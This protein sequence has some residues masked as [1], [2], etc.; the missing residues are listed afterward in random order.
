[1]SDNYIMLLDNSGPNQYGYNPQMPPGQMMGHPMSLAAQTHANANA[2]TNNGR[3]ASLHHQSSANNVPFGSNDNT[4]SNTPVSA[5]SAPIAAAGPGS[6]NSVASQGAAPQSHSQSTPNQ[7]QAPTASSQGPQGQ[8]QA[9]SLANLATSPNANGFILKI[10]NL[11]KNITTRE[12]T[13]IFSLVIDDILKIDLNNFD[14]ESSPVIFAYFKTFNTC[15]TTLKL[16]N[17]KCIFGNDVPIHVEIDESL[18]FDFNNLSINSAAAAASQPHSSTAAA[19]SLPNSAGSLGPNR[20]RFSFND[21]FQEFDP[22]HP[23]AN[24]PPPAGP[25]QPPLGGSSS[26]QQPAPSSG[27][28]SSQAP[29]A[30]TGPQPSAWNGTAPG[31][32][33]AAAP[34]QHP[35]PNSS[36]PQTPLNNL[37]FDWNQSNS[38]SLASKNSSANRRT[39]SAFFQSNFSNNLLSNSFLNSNLNQLNQPLIN[40]LPQSRPPGNNVPVPGGQPPQGVP[41]GSTPNSAPSSAVAQSSGQ[42]PAQ[43]Q[44]LDTSQ[45]QGV[46]D[47][48]PQLSPQEPTTTPAT[49]LHDQSQSSELQGPQNTSGSNSNVTS[50]VQQVSANF[51]KDVPD[52]SLLARVPPPA[53][54]ADQNPPCNTLYVGNLPPDATEQELRALFSPQKGFR[55]LSFRTKTNS[56]NPGSNNHGPMCF[57]EFEDVAHATRALAE[58]YGRIL[59]RSSGSNGKGGIRLSFSKNPLGVRGPQ[60][61]SSS[62]QVNGNFNY[63]YHVKPN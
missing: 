53:N 21:P 42:L 16:L 2:N 3:P 61:R 49:Q 47:Q 52:L 27:S 30:S 41:P 28:A 20:S 12:A 60:R 33:P 17:Q 48:Q 15:I 6:A 37:N 29:A 57:V 13:V 45:D 34:G 35:A 10:T 59:P 55:R 56:S 32:A 31:S 19:P 22:N 18:S 46:V 25:L 11:P 36:Q 14:P 40:Q 9:Q 23:H 58:L 5:S 50:P 44:P 62:N 43:N 24:A 63:N 38:A 4:S 54:P 51:R 1:M 39:S 26:N 7:G 8:D